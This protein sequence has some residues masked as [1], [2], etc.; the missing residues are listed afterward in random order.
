MISCLD[1]VYGADLDIDLDANIHL[2]I[3]EDVDSPTL[4]AQESPFL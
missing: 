3:S 2:L 1:Q 4:V